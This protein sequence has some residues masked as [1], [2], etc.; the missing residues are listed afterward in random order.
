MVSAHR[1]KEKK[2]N[3]MDNRVAHLRYLNSLPTSQDARVT[4]REDDLCECVIPF[5]AILHPMD[6]VGDNLELK[7]QHE[8]FPMVRKGFVGAKV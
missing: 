5:L 1:I 2:S 3:G 4:L 6:A 8:L 7:A